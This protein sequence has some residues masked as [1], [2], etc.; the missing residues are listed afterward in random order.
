MSEYTYMVGDGAA[1]RE[2]GAQVDVWRGGGWKSSTEDR[3]SIHMDTRVV[4]ESFALKY[5]GADDKVGKSFS[6]YMGGG[7]R[8]GLADSALGEHLAK[9]MGEH[10]GYKVPAGFSPIPDSKRHGYHK[11]HGKGW[12]QWYPDEHPESPG[13]D[14]APDSAAAR[15]KS[16]EG[17]GKGKGQADESGGKSGGQAD[18]GAGKSTGREGDK[19]KGKSVAEM[20]TEAKA[21][22]ASGEKTASQAWSDLL[23]QVDVAVDSGRKAAV[24]AGA[25]K[26]L[27]GFNLEIVGDN[28]QAAARIAMLMAKG[29]KDEED[30]CVVTPPACEGNLGIPRADMPQIMGDTLTQLKGSKKDKWK[31]DAAIAAGADADQPDVSS[32]EQFLASLKDSGIKVTP[33]RRSVGELRATQKEIQALKAAKF[34]CAQLRGEWAPGYPCTVAT[35]PIVVTTDGCV[36][37]GHHRYAAMRM[38]SPE[39]SMPTIEVDMPMHEL[40]ARSINFPGVFRA[41]INDKV[42]KD[43]PTPDFKKYARKAGVLDKAL[44]PSSDLVKGA[45]KPEDKPTKSDDKKQP[46]ESQM[47]EWVDAEY[48]KGKAEGRYE[49][50]KS[51]KPVKKALTLGELVIKGVEKAGHKYKSRKPDGKGGWDYKYDDPSKASWAKHG[52]Y[53]YFRTAAGETLGEVED[54]F[55]SQDRNDKG[56][57]YIVEVGGEGKYFASLRQAKG[58]ALLAESKDATIDGQKDLLANKPK[59]KN[60]YTYGLHFRPPGK[61][62]IPDGHVASG[63][64][65]DFKHGTVSYDRQLSGDERKGHQL[66]KIPTE[67]EVTAL[68]ND[69]AADI[70]ADEDTKATV[71]LW[72]N[73]GRLSVE[74]MFVHDINESGM[75]VEPADIAKRVIEKLRAAKTGLGKGLTWR[76]LVIKAC[77]S[78]EGKQGRGHQVVKRRKER[79]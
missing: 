63:V 1:Y 37:D 72:D 35:L 28:K 17:A 6:S 60:T 52:S 18:E 23:D 24:V 41:D 55:R 66:I 2:K 22:V 76:D 27:E 43:A 67:A 32:Q 33:G 29:I 30:F 31:H 71:A 20:A 79:R 44:A 13:G 36:L 70:E 62:A 50:G 73:K 12:V 7:A 14:N 47:E 61:G 4:D 57:R 40:L 19:P 25:V 69:L 74:K 75:H 78:C 59:A 5:V 45:D 26:T 11:R 39:S 53:Y 16:D 65:A 42:V 51:D 3:K 58:Y 54:S 15:G 49:V 56:T 10:G 48:E 46:S 9:K 34:A 38:I 21:S 77:A 64:H 68:V 8:L